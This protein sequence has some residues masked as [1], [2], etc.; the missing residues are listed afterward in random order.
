MRHFRTFSS[1]SSWA[2]FASRSG[3]ACPSTALKTRRLPRRA[4][5]QC[6]S[7]CDPSTFG[8]RAH[9]SVFFKAELP[10]GSALGACRMENLRRADN[11]D[12]TEAL[13]RNLPG[14][15]RA[16]SPIECRLCSGA[17]CR[18]GARA[19]SRRLTI[20][21]LYRTAAA[22]GRLYRRPSA[23]GSA[24]RHKSRA[25]RQNRS[26]LR[27]MGRRWLAASDC[28]LDTDRGRRSPQLCLQARSRPP[29][30]RIYGAPPYRER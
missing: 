2:L 18:P 28:P 25:A 10:V 26:D 12:D 16:G 24:R 17:G 13:K 14:P 29:R 7:G 3:S 15:W 27:G 20:H 4:E 22:E 19:C 5:G 11:D 6:R 23:P 8:R 30:P 1:L 21:G 9:G